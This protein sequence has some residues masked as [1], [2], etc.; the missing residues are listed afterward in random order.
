V[1]ALARRDLDLTDERAILDR[2]RREA[3]DLLLNCAADN[4]VDAAEADPAPAL[5]VN[6]LA[7]AA[8][9][10]SADETGATLVHFSTDFVFDGTV[11]RP[12]TEGDKPEPQSTYGASKL[13]GE[14]LA[15][16][17]PRAY[18]LRVESLFGGRKP[19]SSIDRIIDALVAGKEAQVF[20]DRI[21]SPSYVPDVVAATLGL[22]DRRV[23]PGL[24]HC[25]NSGW[26]TWE[27]V[28]VEAAAC[29]GVD[30]RLLVPILTSDVAMPARRPR[31][32]ALSNGKL[33]AAGV[34]MPDWRDALRR[35]TL[36]RV[37]TGGCAS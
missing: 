25:V 35:Y 11:D 12:Y 17:A 9:A 23:L 31:F 14:W 18:I 33:A 15:A 37:P 34:S 3:P 19:K 30:A 36:R 1:V 8:L 22:L 21:V 10:R 13:M 5:R 7:V 29:L 27:Q 2:V 24:Y 32:A 6:A 16:E 20:R 28:G 4:R 26:A